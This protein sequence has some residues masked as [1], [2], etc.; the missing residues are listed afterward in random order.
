[1]DLITI[2]GF[3]GNIGISSA[4]ARR[5]SGKPPP[6]ERAE[7][8][9]GLV[10][11]GQHPQR[12]AI[13]ADVLTSNPIVGNKAE[14]V[15]IVMDFCAKSGIVGRL[16]SPDH[17]PRLNPG[18]IAMTQRKEESTETQADGALPDGA[19]DKVTGGEDTNTAAQTMQMIS[20][21]LKM[22]ADTQKEIVKNIR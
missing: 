15:T 11:A 16:T 4:E 1:M 8:R 10:A 19:L 12:E 7:T 13:S 2:L 9:A 6:D 22:A 21:M 17:L 5:K 18:A 20:N 14:N 3:A